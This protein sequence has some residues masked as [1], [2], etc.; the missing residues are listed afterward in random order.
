MKTLSDKEEI[1]LRA[2]PGFVLQDAVIE[3]RTKAPFSINDAGRLESFAL[4]MDRAI[5][6]AEQ[7]I[8]ELKVASSQA[9]WCAEALQ[10]NEPKK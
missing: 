5:W 6:A 9:F 8:K 2:N 1:N 3:A 7:A 4:R 10:T